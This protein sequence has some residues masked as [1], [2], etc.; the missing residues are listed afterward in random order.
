[1][2][3]PGMAVALLTT[4]YGA[5]ATYGLFYPIS[6]KLEIRTKE[7]TLIKEMIIRGVMSIQSGDN[8]RIVAQKLRI[9]LPP[10]EREPETR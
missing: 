6:N 7:E 3:G 8:P 10:D 9:Y 1:M 2:I 4:F 5:L